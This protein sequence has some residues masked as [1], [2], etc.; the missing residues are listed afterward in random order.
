MDVTGIG[1]VADLANTV[2]GRLFPDKSE[3]ERQQLAA[4]L[5]IVQGQLDANKAE[6][7]NPSTFTSGWRPGIGWVCAAA[8]FMQYIA[9]PLLAWAGIVS[10][11]Q[12]PTL[13]GIDDNLWQLM[14][15][16]LGLGGLRSIEKLKGVEGN[17]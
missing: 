7:A 12:F 16:M 6:A 9:R 15:G 14:L 17:R 11:H 4:T 8:L 2:I 1:A 3:Q 5:T 10:G 13:P